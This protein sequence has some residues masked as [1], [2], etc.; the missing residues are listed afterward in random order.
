MTPLP[1]INP[2]INF[3]K[4]L[5]KNGADT[6]KKCFQCSTCSSVCNLSPSRKPFPRKVMLLA[7]WGQADKLASS[8]DIWLCHQCEDCSTHCPRGA[9]PGDVLAAVRSHIFRTFSYPSFMGKALSQPGYLPLLLLFPMLL[10]AVLFFI[11]RGG[12]FS[13]LHEEISYSKFLSHLWI[14][15]MFIGGNILMFFLAFLGLGK[16]WRK[17]KEGAGTDSKSSFVKAALLTVID[18]VFHKK[19]F[20][21]KVN[22]GR[23][24]AHLLIFFGFFGAMATAG[25][26]VLAMILYNV[27]PNL[28]FSQMPPIPMNHPI[29]WLGNISG[30]AGIAGLAIII[31]RRIKSETNTYGDWIFLLM[32]LLVFITGFGSQFIRQAHLVLFAYLTYYIHLVC[33]F[34]ILWYAPYSKFAHMFY[35]TVALIF[36]TMISSEPGKSSGP[37]E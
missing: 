34:F 26:A 13:L 35:R 23:N 15:V 31:I 6:L 8:P 19:F 2:D 30:L 5:K 7:Q 24:I 33:V 11:Y 3:I 1:V 27:D 32:L 29:K 12:N 36:T 37:R 25:L 22:Q 21:C 28:P 10:I 16:F 20:K 14:N 4:S 18:I 17:L 9:R